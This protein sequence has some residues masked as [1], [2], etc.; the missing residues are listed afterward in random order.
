LE[1]G[2]D[3]N[4]VVEQRIHAE[5]DGWNIS[6]AIDLQIVNAN[7]VDIRDYKTTSAW[8]VMNEKIEWEHQLNLYAYLV[9]RVKKVPV[10][11]V[12]IVAIIRDW[13]RRDAANKEDYP[14]APIKEIPVK[15]WTF[16]ER[17]AFVIDRVHKHAEADFA[18]E[19]EGELPDCTPQEMWETQSTWAVKK[20]GG[21]RAK[22][23]HQSEAE[24]QAALESLGKG[25]EIEHR[26]GERKRCANF[27]QVNQ[28]CQQ[29]LNYMENL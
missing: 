7:G 27:C 2:K 10:T 19:T 26:P 12:G 14:Q 18:M 8:A 29:Y 21:V 24:A 9:E 15:L 22:S 5:V 11:S 13:S 23:V 1:H 25:Y 16:E 17:E 4:H 3:D 20:T 6:G 28:Y